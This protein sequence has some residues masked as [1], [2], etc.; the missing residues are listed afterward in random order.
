[1]SE[2]ITKPEKTKN[3]KRVEQGKR[4]AAIS[5]AAKERKRQQQEEFF[6]SEESEATEGNVLLLG[7]GVIGAAFLLTKFSSNRGRTPPTFRSR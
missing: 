2:Q 1:M 4:L 7:I 3:P 5:R 6:K